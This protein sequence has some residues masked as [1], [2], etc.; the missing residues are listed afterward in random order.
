VRGDRFRASKIIEESVLGDP[1]IEVRFNT[2]VQEFVG[3]HIKLQALK[4]INTKTG[5]SST[6][7]AD[8]A[9]IFIGLEPNSACLRGSPVRLDRWGFVITG[10]DLVH[11]GERPP[12][13]AQRDPSL[14]ETSVPGIFAAGD[15]RVGSTKQVASATGEGATAALLIRDY[16]KTV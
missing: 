12:R 5:A 6:L 10:H 16:L 1:K 9:F 7:A 8:G 13:F 15:V 11:A 3:A 14:L 2:A 4:L